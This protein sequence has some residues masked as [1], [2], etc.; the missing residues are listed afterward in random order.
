MTLRFPIPRAILRIA[1]L[2]LV[3]LLV[4]IQTGPLCA[5]LSMIAAPARAMS[6]L[7]VM[8]DCHE[9]QS[10][11][12]DTLLPPFFCDRIGVA[13][14]ADEVAVVVAVDPVPAMI[15]SSPIIAMIVDAGRPALPPPRSAHA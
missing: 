4:S 7:P 2:A 9:M 1:A 5:E 10:S 14:V 3:A 15:W 13:V 6:G 8:P 12:H 11:H